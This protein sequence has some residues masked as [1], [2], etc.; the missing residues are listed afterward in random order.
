MLSKKQKMIQV[1]AV[2][3]EF[4]DDTSADELLDKL[5]EMISGGR[6]PLESIE[7]LIASAE[8]DVLVSL[9]FRIKNRISA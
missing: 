7:L 4:A 8:N 6:D 1:I 5:T 2:E 9:L 3:R